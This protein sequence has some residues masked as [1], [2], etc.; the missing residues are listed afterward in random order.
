[1]TTLR[2]G[3]PLHRHPFSKAFAVAYSD[4]LPTLYVVH[5]RA[6]PV[7]CGSNSTESHPVPSWRNHIQGWTNVRESYSPVLEQGTLLD[8]RLEVFYTFITTATLGP[9]KNGARRKTRLRPSSIQIMRFTGREILEI[10]G[11]AVKLHLVREMVL[12]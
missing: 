9:H 3:S 12:S 11:W 8:G 10:S 1:M 4:S 6:K 7:L 2:G 5:G